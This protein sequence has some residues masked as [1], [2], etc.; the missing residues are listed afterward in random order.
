MTSDFM[1]A[2][3]QGKERKRRRER[4]ARLRLGHA[5]FKERHR[6]FQAEMGGSSE[7]SKEL[8]KKIMD[9]SKVNKEPGGQRRAQNCLRLQ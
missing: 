3:D 5:E 8:R 6:E 4:Q 2:M 1:R 9:R 7:T